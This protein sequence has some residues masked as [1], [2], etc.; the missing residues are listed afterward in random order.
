MGK[1]I[2]IFVD[3]TGNEGG[4]LPDESRTNVYKLFRATRTGPDSLIEPAKQIAFYIPGVGTSLPG[5]NPSLRKR[6]RNV[7]QQATGRGVTNRIIEGYAAII[8]VWK[9]GDRI[10]LFGF[11]RGAYIARCVANVLD[12]VGVPTKDRDKP[13]SFEPSALSRL[14]A[15]AVRTRYRGGLPRRNMKAREVSADNFRKRYVSAV[16]GEPVGALPVFIGVWDT[17]AAI[18]WNHLLIAWFIKMITRSEHRYDLHFPQDVPYARHAMAIDEYRRDFV[19]VPWGGSGTVSYDDLEGLQRFDQV[20][21]AGNHSDIGG[22]Y[23]ENESRLSDISLHWMADLI[24]TKLP[25]AQG[26]LSNLNCSNVSR[27]PM[28]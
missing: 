22:S 28:E 1:N 19:R 5:S 12:T 26:S 14:A 17:V 7:I 20:W 21:F 2:L 4:L 9:P 24:T 13:L 6:I 10:Y 15:E 8:S 18:G 16:G 11:S 25:N 23:P 27:L 3:G